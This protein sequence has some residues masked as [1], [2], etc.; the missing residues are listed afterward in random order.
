MDRVDPNALFESLSQV[1][2]A[3]FEIWLTITYVLCMF[4][5]TIYRPQQIGSVGLFRFSYILFT[6]YLM[7]PVLVRATFAIINADRRSLN[8]PAGPLE[9]A[10]AEMVIVPLFMGLSKILFA[11]ALLCGL[12][13]LRHYQ[14]RD[15]PPVLDDDR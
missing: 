2:S 5:A 4:L 9:P 8:R 3:P 13:S 6:L 1:F 7:I 11:I 14:R 12:A 15:L 10:Y